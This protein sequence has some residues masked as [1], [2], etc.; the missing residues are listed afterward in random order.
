MYDEILEGYWERQFKE[1]EVSMDTDDEN[2]MIE[3]AFKSPNRRTKKHKDE[4]AAYAEMESRTKKK[5]KSK[6]DE[7]F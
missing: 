2:E 4:K 7:L 1:E 3:K 5:E 6:A